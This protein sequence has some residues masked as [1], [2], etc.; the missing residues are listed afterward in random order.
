MKTLKD[1]SHSPLSLS[2]CPIALHKS[3][4]HE[5]LPDLYFLPYYCGHSSSFLI[6]DIRLQVLC[7]LSSSWTAVAEQSGCQDYWRGVKRIG[8]AFFYITHIETKSRKG[9]AGLGRWFTGKMLYM[10]AA[11]PEFKSPQPM[12]KFCK[13]IW[14]IILACKKHRQRI[15]RASWTSQD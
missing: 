13:C 6:V 1:A 9:L 4:L 14:P 5:P 15:S 11:G 8:K 12:Y 10:Q 3:K 2:Q 7:F